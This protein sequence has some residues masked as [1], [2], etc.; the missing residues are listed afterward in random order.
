[1]DTVGPGGEGMDLDPIKTCARCGLRYDWRHS[2][3]SS[4]KMTYCTAL[5]ER[6]DLGFTLD[7]LLKY[8]P[9]GKKDE[10]ATGV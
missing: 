5:C 1:M 9:D 10:A 2:S 8:Q 6:N 7:A 3:T 4:L